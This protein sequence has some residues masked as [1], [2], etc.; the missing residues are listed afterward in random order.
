MSNLTHQNICA[1]IPVL[2]GEGF[3]FAAPW[4]PGCPGWATTVPAG[5]VVYYGRLER[6]T[7]GCNARGTPGRTGTCVLL[8]EQSSIT[9]SVTRTAPKATATGET[10]EEALPPSTYTAVWDASL[11]LKPAQPLV[12]RDCLIGGCLLLAGHHDH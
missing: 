7:E 9:D 11:V 12:R 6:R 10:G 1:I 3:A 5:A 2:L 8:V 4:M